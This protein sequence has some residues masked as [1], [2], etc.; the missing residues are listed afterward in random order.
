MLKGSADPAEA[1]D[2]H[3]YL[4]GRTIDLVVLGLPAFGSGQSCTVPLACN[5]LNPEAMEREESSR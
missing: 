3:F 1:H 2:N 5:H 4:T